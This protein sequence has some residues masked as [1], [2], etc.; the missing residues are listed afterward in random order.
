MVSVKYSGA[1]IFT[2]R[3]EHSD[4]PKKMTRS[5]KIAEKTMTRASRARALEKGVRLSPLVG[6]EP[7]EPK[8]TTTRVSKKPKRDDRGVVV[9]RSSEFADHLELDEVTDEYVAA[10]EKY[11]AAVKR[12]QESVGDFT[13]PRRSVQR[14][15]DCVI[16]RSSGQMLSYI[17]QPRTL[18]IPKFRVGFRSGDIVNIGSDRIMGNVFE[19]D[20]MKANTEPRWIVVKGHSFV[21]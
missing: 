15:F 1:I 14:F 4:C 16:D 2:H 19:L 21:L 6:L 7:V 3:G 20:R 12:A 10:V 8:T 9:A 17:V 18:K 5:G 11:C 13:V